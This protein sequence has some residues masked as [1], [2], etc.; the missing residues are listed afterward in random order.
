[1]KLVIL[2]ATGGTGQEIVR[3]A[4]ERGHDV[5]AFVRSPEKL[6][7][8]GDRITV[9]KGDLLNSAELAK[10]IEGHDAV[11]SGFGPRIPIAKED[12]HLLERFAAALTGAMKR[13]QVKRVVI[14]STA[15]LF[16]DAILPPA[17]LFGRLFFPGVVADATAMEEIFGKSELDW[18]IVRPPQLTDTAFTGKYR[19]RTGYLPFAGFKISRADVANCMVKA[20]ESQASI[21]KVIGVSN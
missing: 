21:E 15:F 1:M 6:A 3:Q 10:A 5:T 7:A 13:T 11:V 19:V 20:A 12:A 16:K 18:T 8:Y 4:I 17:H 2:G 9:R 14:E